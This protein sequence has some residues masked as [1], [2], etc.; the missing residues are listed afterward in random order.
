MEM[1]PVLLKEFEEEA[2][3][4]RKFL[5]R[6]PENKWDWRPHPKSMDLKSLTVHI[7]ELPSWAEM[8]LNTDGLDFALTPYE[9]TPVRSTKDLKRIFEEAYTSGK[10]ALN[11]AT[12]QQLDGKWILSHGDQELANMT[13]YETIRHSLNQTA[14]HRAQLGVYFRLLDIPVPGS[15][16][17]SADE[18]SF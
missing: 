18:Q 7:A 17:P 14:H 5:D 8:A 16:G 11:N 2:A 10:N 1:I 9:P 13:K 6:V 15:Y 3:T 4:T 12:D